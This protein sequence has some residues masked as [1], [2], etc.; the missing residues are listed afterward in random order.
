[1]EKGKHFLQKSDYTSGPACMRMVLS[2]F[3]IESSEIELKKMLDANEKTGTSYES[4]ITCGIDKYNL[5][6][7]SG[8]DGSLELLEYLASTGWSVI[9]CY[10]LGTMPHY[11]LYGNTNKHHVFLRDPA[12]TKRNSLTIHKFLKL[13]R[14]DMKSFKKLNSFKWYA[15]FRE[16]R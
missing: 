8:E 9:I 2:D 14:V 10:T 1:M 13:W 6:C 7:K 12:F 5:Y 15:A 4:I 16:I 3:G 11:A